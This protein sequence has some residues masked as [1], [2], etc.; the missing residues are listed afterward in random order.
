MFGC[1]LW[2]D[3]F[4]TSLFTWLLAKRMMSDSRCWFLWGKACGNIFFT[5][6]VNQWCVPKIKVYLECVTGNRL[7]SLQKRL[8]Q[9]ILPN[10]SSMATPEFWMSW[11]GKNRS[12]N[13][14]WPPKEDYIL[15]QTLVIWFYF[16]LELVKS[17]SSSDESDG[18]SCGK[19][20]FGMLLV[21]RKVW[22][23]TCPKTLGSREKC[24]W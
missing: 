19:I 10:L 23:S 8:W 1:F 18:K 7:E 16:F 13:A 24:W 21:P 4:V 14:K 12:Q 6:L 9:M 2:R 22:H 20:W 3:V 17:R 5:V 11:H 15:V